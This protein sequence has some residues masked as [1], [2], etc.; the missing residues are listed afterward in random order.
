MKGKRRTVSALDRL[1]RARRRY[2]ILA[3][4]GISIDSGLPAAQ[5]FMTTL[6]ERIG[7]GLQSGKKVTRRLRELMN[8]ARRDRRDDYDFLRFE[9][10]LQ[11]LRDYYDDALD[12]VSIYGDAVAPNLNHYVLASLIGR[13]HVVCTTNFDSL[14]E[15]ACR[16]LGIPFTQVYRDEHFRRW[17]EAPH[18]FTNPVFKIHGS[19]HE[20]RDGQRVWAGDSLKATLDQVGL[21]GL[22]FSSELGKAAFF[23]RM[24]ARH[25]ILVLG[26]SGGDDFDVC[27]TIERQ[28]S[29][30][31]MFWIDHQRGRWILQRP[32]DLRRQRRSNRP[33]CERLL[34]K[35]AA[36]PAAP[37][38]SNRL[39]LLRMPT[40]E[41]MEALAA[42]QG[43]T[44]Q[45]DVR[46]QSEQ[47]PP[48]ARAH[49]SA[50]VA[51]YLGDARW[52]S[53]HLAGELFR[54]FEL[55]TE[56]RECAQRGRALVRRGDHAGHVMTGYLHCWSLWGQDRHR[57]GARLCQRLLASPRPMASLHSLKG[58]ANVHYL[59]VE[60][61]SLLGEAR[62]AQRAGRRA[63]AFLDLQI[64]RFSGDPFFRKVKADLLSTLG[65]MTLSLGS[66]ER[67]RALFQESLSL[68]GAI[69]DIYG[70]AYVT[71]R[72]ATVARMRSDLD[73]A[74]ALYDKSVALCTT[75]GYR[76]GR[77]QCLVGQA[78]VARRRGDVHEAL[79]LLT[80]A[81]AI[82][83][84]SRDLRELAS[85]YRAKAD[86][87]RLSGRLAEASALYGKADRLYVRAEARR[88]RLSIA[89]ARADIHRLR[90]APREAR[91]GFDRA[92]RDARRLGARLEN[93]H[94]LLGLA[95]LGTRRRRHLAAAHRTY[96]DEGC[97]WGAQEALRL[98]LEERV[99]A[100]RAGP[101]SGLDFVCLG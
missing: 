90:G 89:L 81:E 61:L 93:A 22:E 65:N 59:Y 39:F 83:S 9:W 74:R 68:Y 26:Y 92:R 98:S 45:R 69:G 10:L 6:L 41:A 66:I 73:T 49:L 3:G 5:V 43:I 44:P 80:E 57:E 100:R 1:L 97:A 14:I 76:W 47:G 4:A 25:D 94:A 7:D 16:N 40:R 29:P 31:R 56:F 86:L 95:S 2:L 35:L 82:F 96:S 33:S 50:W 53:F 85:A 20:Y 87:H 71:G 60:H 79:R 28:A 67:S 24:L 18:E 62:R 37:R 78:D 72:I 32:A 91:A 17:L 55:L 58:L 38:R 99:P 88:E 63:L 15:D 21:Q 101:P 75:I 42:S 46:S 19:L 27:P 51:R 70:V 36:G 77:G 23:T 52:K 54:Y 84:A 8:Q 12:V 30:R 48:R 11:Y 13:G 34:L 64:H